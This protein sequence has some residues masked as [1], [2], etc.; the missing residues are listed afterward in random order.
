MKF[1]AHLYYE[2]NY[3]NKYK[4]NLNSPISNMYII[5]LH[6]HEESLTFQFF[7]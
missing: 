6:A 3:F 2:K 1:D 7:L 5:Y 4:A